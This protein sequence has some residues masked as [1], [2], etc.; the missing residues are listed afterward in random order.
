MSVTGPASTSGRRW[1]AVTGRHATASEC[2]YRRDGGQ[3]GAVAAVRCTKNH[4]QSRRSHS[5]GECSSHRVL[6]RR[7]SA[8]SH[9]DCSRSSLRSKR[10]GCQ[11]EPKCSAAADHAPRR[12]RQHGPGSAPSTKPEAD[13]SKARATV[14]LSH[15]RDICEKTVRGT[16]TM[17]LGL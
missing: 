15:D 10:A 6:S 2:S 17:K 1:C 13:P 9:T 8:C 16:R 12:S 7:S 11:H 5:P 3:V 4:I 14:L